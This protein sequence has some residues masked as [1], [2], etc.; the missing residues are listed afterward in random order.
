VSQPNTAFLICGRDNKSN[1][2]ITELMFSWGVST[3]T[4]TRAK[5]LARTTLG[6]TPTIFEIVQA[7]MRES[8]CIIALFTPDMN[9]TLR[10]EFVRDAREGAGLRQPRANVLFEAGVALG[11]YPDKTI[12]VDMGS[13]E[14]G[15]DFWEMIQCSVLGRSLRYTWLSMDPWVVY[16]WT[17]RPPKWSS[18]GSSG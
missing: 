7:G 18:V 3:M 10:R 12:L 1:D 6:R 11:L 5:V 13:V 14:I 2:A 8:Q 4:W 9:G 16:R 15:S 17:G